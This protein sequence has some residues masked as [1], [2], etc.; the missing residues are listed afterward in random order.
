M[1]TA[2]IVTHGQPSAPEAAGLANRALAAKVQAL[3][4][5][6]QVFG[7]TLAEADALGGAIARSSAGGVVYP[8]FMADGWFT[9]T[10]LP[11]RLRAAGARMAD[12]GGAWRILQ[13]FGLDPRLW[14]LAAQVVR[15]AC[16]ASGAPDHAPAD[17]SPSD[18]AAPDLLLAAHGSFRSDAPSRV[19]R[20]VAGHVQARCGLTRAEAAFIDQAPRLA[21]ARGFGAASL[22]LPFFAAAGGHVVDDLPQALDEAGFQGRILPALGLDPRVPALIAA[23]LV[24]SL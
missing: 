24:D 4:P 5:E 15:E 8:M 2:L 13:P 12:E 23:A 20:A 11:A 1:R 21:D 7:P 17:H 3:L 16:A 22:C 9:Q 19:A 10:H 18:L 14:D 6:W